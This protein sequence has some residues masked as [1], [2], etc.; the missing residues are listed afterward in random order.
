MPRLPFFLGLL[1]CVVV[2]DLWDENLIEME[3][4]TRKGIPFNWESRGYAGKTAS[5]DLLI[6]MKT[7]HSLN[8]LEVYSFYS[9]TK[10]R[11]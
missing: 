10:C 6:V 4:D 5:I 9:L 1:L 2:A 8:E 11:N 7:K 3:K